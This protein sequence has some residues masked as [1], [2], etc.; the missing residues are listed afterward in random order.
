MMMLKSGRLV[1]K[2]M[3]EGTLGAGSASLTPN[4]ID[5]RVSRPRRIL[6]GARVNIQIKTVRGM[7][8]MLEAAASQGANNAQY[9]DAAQ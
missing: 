7:G 3:I 8:Y 4:A 1:S 2:E 6:E 9:S 5:Q